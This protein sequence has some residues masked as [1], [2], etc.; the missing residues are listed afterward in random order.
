MGKSY[1]ANTEAN[2]AETLVETYELS[3]LIMHALV[4]VIGLH[5]TAIFINVYSFLTLFKLLTELQTV[6]VFIPARNVIVFHCQKS[7][8]YNHALLYESSRNDVET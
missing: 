8:P 4:H 5:T 1:T 6:T 7:I 3:T 2:F